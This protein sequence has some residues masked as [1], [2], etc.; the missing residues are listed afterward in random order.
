[1]SFLS[2]KTYFW[3]LCYT[4]FSNRLSSFSTLRSTSSHFMACFDVAT[5]KIYIKKQW[6]THRDLPAVWMASSAFL[7]SFIIPSLESSFTTYVVYILLTTTRAPFKHIVK[8]TFEHSSIYFSS[9]YSFSFYFIS[10]FCTWIDFHH[11]L[12][13]N[14]TNDKHFFSNDIAAITHST[15][16]LL[17]N[18]NTFNNSYI[19][20]LGSNM[21][22]SNKKLPEK[23]TETIK[24]LINSS[25]QNDFI[26]MTFVTD[27][28]SYNA[29]FIG[30]YN[31][32]VL[33]INSFIESSTV[34][35]THSITQSEYRPVLN[36]WITWKLYENE[37]NQTMKWNQCQIKESHEFKWFFGSYFRWL[38]YEWV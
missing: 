4:T 2:K 14:Y 36:L 16:Y 29:S 37:N 11:T 10:F 35:W 15:L 7:R 28:L 26:P 18:E 25:L 23:W 31:A 12:H 9:S 21:I 30:D 1:M 33:K 27:I 3:Y 38:S 22:S 19:S 6:Y 13:T 8:F 34:K 32:I 20:V 24:A 5:R 17:F